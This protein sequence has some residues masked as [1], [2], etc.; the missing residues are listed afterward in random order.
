MVD[1]GSTDRLDEAKE[2][3]SSI[4]QHEK[5]KGKPL[6]IFANKQ[7]LE[8][9]VDD[10]TVAQ[11]LD[12]DALLGDNRGNSNVVRRNLQAIQNVTFN[13]QDTV[14]TGAML[15]LYKLKIL[16]ILNVQVK[17]IA[18][19]S[20]NQNRTDPSISRGVKWLLNSIGKQYDSVADRV[21][22]DVMEQRQKEAQQRRERAERVR[23]IREERER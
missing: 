18:L 10:D 2:V 16:Y 5:I 9:A 21:R 4:A 19:K 12:L 15:L 20:A 3:F 7:D 6:L 14:S 8:E 13:L 17:C 11:R 23:R 22:A 1:S